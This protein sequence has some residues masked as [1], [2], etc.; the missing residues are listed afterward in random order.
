MADCANEFLNVDADA[1]PST[2]AAFSFFCHRDPCRQR[3]V[4]CLSDVKTSVEAR[5]V[6]CRP[7]YDVLSRSLNRTPHFNS[8][9][10]QVVRVNQRS[11]VPYKFWAIPELILIVF[12]RI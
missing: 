5:V 4:D 3:K 10:Q 6:C 11:L 8:L 9:L 1:V 12:L 7:R 2:D